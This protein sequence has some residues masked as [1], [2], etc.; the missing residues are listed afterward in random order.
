[1]V[2]YGVLSA[3]IIDFP[4]FARTRLRIMHLRVRIYTHKFATKIRKKNELCKYFGKKK[5]RKN[6][7]QRRVVIDTP[8]S[9][10]PRAGVEPA[11]IAP[12]VFETSASTDSA[13]WA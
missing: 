12:L 13:I 3:E 4:P 8:L 1:M 7:K 11:R 6:N 10:V 5:C 2:S 9:C